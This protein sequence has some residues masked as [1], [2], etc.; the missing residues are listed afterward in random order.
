MPH[1]ELTDEEAAALFPLVKQASSTQTVIRRP[2]RPRSI[3]SMLDRGEAAARAGNN[4]AL[5]AVKK[6]DGPE[7]IALVAL[8]R[9]AGSPQPTACP[10]SIR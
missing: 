9:R 10:A 1:L 4:R 7:H 8:Q 2:A 5:R 6:C 3:L